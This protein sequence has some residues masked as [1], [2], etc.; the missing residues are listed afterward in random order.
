MNIDTILVPYDFAEASHHALAYAKGLAERFG[1]SLQLLHVLP[2]PNAPYAYMPLSPDAPATYYVPPDTV[3][4]M[5]KEA[6]V[7]LD[8]VLPSAERQSFRALTF[9]QLGDPRQEILHHA[10]RQRVDLIVMG[11]HGRGGAA[12]LL[13][14]SVAERVVRTAPCPVLTV[15]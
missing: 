15:R 9:V 6:T 12:H 3:D 5:M 14:G 13:L 1:S 2:D 7:R 8:G 10:A 4:E 11:T